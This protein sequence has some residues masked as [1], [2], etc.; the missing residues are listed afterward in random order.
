MLNVFYVTFSYE[1]KLISHLKQ[2]HSQQLSIYTL[3]FPLIH[4]TNRLCYRFQLLVR[5][6]TV[7]LKQ[8]LK[9]EDRTEC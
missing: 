6:Q 3:S 8:V 9:A 1:C 5:R 2:T 7:Q 4:E